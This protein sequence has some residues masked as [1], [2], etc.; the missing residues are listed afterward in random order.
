MTDERNPYCVCCGRWF[1]DRGDG[2]RWEGRLRD[3][4]EDCAWARCDAFP[5]G[6]GKVPASPP[7]VTSLAQAEA[8]LEVAAK[9]RARE[10]VMREQAED[11]A[12]TAIQMLIGVEGQAQRAVLDIAAVLDALLPE[13]LN[14]TE[15][16]PLQTLRESLRVAAR[17]EFTYANILKMCEHWMMGEPTIINDEPGKITVLLHPRFAWMPVPRRTTRRIM[18]RLFSIRPNGVALHVKVAP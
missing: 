5:G 13:R 9:L 8:L 2:D 11:Q 6:C 7:K 14:S 16:S 12:D 17:G 15:P 10:R 18:G 1:E 4:C 3:Y